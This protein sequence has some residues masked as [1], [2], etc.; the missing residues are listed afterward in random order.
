MHL[1]KEARTAYAVMVLGVL[2]TAFLRLPLINGGPLEGRN[3]FTFT[4]MSFVILTWMR[5]T[6]YRFVRREVLLCFSVVAVLFVVW[7]FVQTL[8]YEFIEML[9]TRGRIAWYSYY[10][11]IV[12]APPLIF[13]A[14]LF[15]GLRESERVDRRWTVVIVAGVAMALLFLT[16][17][18]HHL[19]FRFPEELGPKG[20]YDPANNHEY[21]PL[22]YAAWIWMATMGIAAI[23]VLVWRGVRGGFLRRLAGTA[24]V[25]VAMASVL[26][27]YGLGWWGP[28]DLIMYSEAT[29]LF[30]IAFIE[31]LVVAGIFPSNSGYEAMWEA[32]S[33]RG[34]FVDGKGGLT[35]VSLYAPTVTAEQVESAVSR[36]L[37]LEGGNDALVAHHVQGGTAFWVRDLT[38]IRAL[39]ERLEDLGDA[40]AGEQAMLTAENELARGREALAQREELYAKLFS[41]TELQLHELQRVLEDIPDG[42]EEFIEGMH[43]AALVAVYIKR[44]ANLMLLGEGGAV[45]VRELALALGETAE[46]LRDLGVRTEVRADVEGLVQA[47]AALGAYAAFW[48]VIEETESVP[49]EI[50]AAIVPADGAVELRVSF[51]AGE[52]PVLAYAM[53]LAGDAP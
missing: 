22:F 38:S 35:G 17:D 31:S 49:S 30:I 47:E 51:D 34:G 14:S 52:R 3:I 23:V 36:P 44:Y 4:S 1:G 15:A 40:L 39:R 48:R 25:I 50:R 32:S 53:P 33:L 20:E 11:P 24:V 37:V 13:V 18:L 28:D 16:N 12:L 29:C 27:G 46:H 21:G 7:L 45:D 19:A 43:R 10:V 26:P 9:P 6:H 5:L 2:V 8:K 42:D 41:N